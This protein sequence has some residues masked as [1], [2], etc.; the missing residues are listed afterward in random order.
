MSTVTPTSAVKKFLTEQGYEVGI[1]EKW[2]SWAKIRQD[3]FGFVDLIAVHP[4]S[5]MILYVQI[6]SASNMAARIKKIQGITNGVPQALANFNS[7]MTKLLVMGYKKKT[8]TKPADIL[9]VD[10]RDKLEYP[11]LQVTDKVDKFCLI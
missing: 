1:T 3:L 5:G 6:T 7:S 9:I 2:N 11:T 4:I 10:M 8:K